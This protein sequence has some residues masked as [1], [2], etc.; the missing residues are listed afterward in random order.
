MCKELEESTN[1][2]MSTIDT[3]PERSVKPLLD[4]IYHI[5]RQEEAFFRGEIG[6]RIQFR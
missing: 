1:E 3:N 2:M 6:K 5:R 4:E